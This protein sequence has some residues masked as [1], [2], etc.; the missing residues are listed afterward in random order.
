M[1]QYNIL[2]SESLAREKQASREADAARLGAGKVSVE[3]LK[4]ENG[5]FSA[6]PLGRFRVAA[7]GQQPVHHAEQ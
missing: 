4:Q 2:D 6:L 7:V 1:A 5:F 3:A